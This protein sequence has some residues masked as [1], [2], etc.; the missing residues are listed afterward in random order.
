MDKNLA[1]PD[2]ANK[3]IRRAFL[4]P[5]F[6]TLIVRSH[7]TIEMFLKLS[8]NHAINAAEFR[9]FDRLPFMT[10]VE[11]AI[12]LEQLR[13]DSHP[14]L[15]AFNRVRNR[16]AHNPYTI[17]TSRDARDLR[18]CFSANHREMI[19]KIKKKPVNE[20]SSREVVYST[21]VCVSAELR[22]SAER[23]I[24]MRISHEVTMRDIKDVLDS[25]PAAKHEAVRREHEEKVT[26]KM[27]KLLAGED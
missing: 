1:R 12:V 19:L 2:V 8:I 26:K 9:E 14:L 23:R 5:N 3:Q 17:F 22:A 27:E 6:L 16:F 4:A 25:I 18:N 13:K 21:L 24:R 11:L 20:L 10:R 15:K 7:H